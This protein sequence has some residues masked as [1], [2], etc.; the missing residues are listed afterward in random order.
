MDEETWRQAWDL[1]VFGYINMC[2]QVFT[3]MCERGSGV[4]INII[5]AGG[6]RPSPGYIVGSAG[7]SA[8]MSLSRALGSDS[9]RKGVRVLGLNPGVIKTGRMETQLRRT[10]QHKWGDEQRWEELIS[11]K[12]PPGK[13]EN[14]ADMTA[15]LASDLSSFTTGTIVTVDGGASSRYA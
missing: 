8:L 10:A 7:N 12:F 6:E 1:K 9:L 5:G 13:P 4:I 2:R 3:R 11:K 15:L 14:I